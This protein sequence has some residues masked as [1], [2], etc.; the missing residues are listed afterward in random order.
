MKPLKAYFVMGAAASAILMSSQVIAAKPDRIDIPPPPD[1]DIKGYPATACHPSPVELAS[2]NQGRICNPPDSTENLKVYCPIVR[3][4]MI[5]GNGTF[6]AVHIAQYV[7]AVEC[8]AFSLDQHYD[9][10][11]QSTSFVAI[12][13]GETSIALVLEDTVSLGTYSLSCT[14][15]ADSCIF[16]YF[17]LEYEGDEYEETTD[18]NR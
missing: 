9:V 13:D 16:G 7:Q 6:I 15:P 1:Y 11:D 5:D 10:I 18:Y 2:Y 12:P 4:D 8:T 3:D 14:L 17:V